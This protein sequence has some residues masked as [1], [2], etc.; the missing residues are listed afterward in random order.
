MKSKLKLTLIAFALIFVTGGCS[1]ITVD[2]GNLMRPPK[3]TGDEEKIIELIEENSGDNYK[4]K[5]PENGS[6]RSAIAMYD[7]DGDSQNEAIAFYETS[8]PADTTTHMLV[9]YENSDGWNLAG[10]AQTQNTNIDRVE[11]ADVTGDKILDIIIGYKTFNSNVNQLNV[12]SYSKGTAT[13]IDISQTYTSFV[14]NDF[15]EDLKNDILTLSINTEKNSEA[16]LLSYNESDKI[17]SPISGTEIDNNITS[18]EN[19]ISGKTNENQTAAFIDGTIGTDKICTQLIYYDS[20][21]NSLENGLYSNSYDYINPTIRD[22]KT[23]CTDIDKNEI[24]EIP[25]LTKMPHTSEE[26]EEYIATK[27]I[28]NTFDTTSKSLNEVSTMVVNYNSAYYFKLS[29]NLKYITTAQINTQDNSMTIYEWDGDK[30]NNQLLTI[31][32]YNSDEWSTTGKTDGYFLI[33][34]DTSNAY[35]C[36]IYENE[37]SYKFTDTEIQ[38][39]FSLFSEYTEN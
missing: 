11:F 5:Y 14:I 13:P 28:W 15:N 4:L 1:P 31:K 20:Q 27:A 12:Y 18:F 22:G 26:N 30:I 6:V 10:D 17:I 9:M 34:E 2:S 23:F 32:V 35:C 3:A 36:K 38:T 7:L 24:I 37:G 39:S 19:I 25:T 8:D 21:K 33:K 16:V 29:D